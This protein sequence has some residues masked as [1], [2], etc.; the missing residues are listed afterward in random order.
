MSCYLDSANDYA[1]IT[2]AA[3]LGSAYVVSAFF[4]YSLDD[5]TASNEIGRLA[6]SSFSTW[7]IIKSATSIGFYSNGADR[8][9]WTGLTSGAW[10][11]IAL[12][13]DGTGSGN[14][15]MRLFGT[16]GIEIAVST[17]SNLYA[18]TAFG[19][20]NAFTMG[21]NTAYA[22]TAVGRYRYSRQWKVGLTAG[23]FAAE[24]ALGAT[25]AGTPAAKTANLVHS[26][27]LPDATDTTDWATTPP[28]TLTISG[29][30][31]SANEPSFGGGGASAI[32]GR[33]TLLGVGL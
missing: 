5:S 22:P 28:G 20:A 1:E 19:K 3:N 15:I 27:G 31:T 14:N 4:W 26:W 29:A 12:V 7:A 30:S 8:A 16:D 13:N 10:Y 17:G 2:T 6:L 23:E 25:S 24:A 21:N 18:N 32:G 9:T 11:G 33:M